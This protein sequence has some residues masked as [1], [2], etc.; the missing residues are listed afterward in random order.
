MYEKQANIL[1][2]LNEYRLINW[3]CILNHNSFSILKSIWFSIDIIVNVKKNLKVYFN[4]TK[5]YTPSNSILLCLLP[6]V[7]KWR[8]AVFQ[9]YRLKKSEKTKE[10]HLTKFQIILHC[11]Q[12]SL[13]QQVHAYFQVDF[14]FQLYVHS[15]FKILPDQ[16]IPYSCMLIVQWSTTV[17]KVYNKNKQI[18]WWF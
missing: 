8:Q 17:L 2:F 16:K 5:I 11:L 6:S 9:I 14:S 18:F 4:N 13:I 7:D 1:V 15:V 12:L 10:K 3:C